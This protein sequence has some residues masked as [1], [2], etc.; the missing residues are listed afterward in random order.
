MFIA[1]RGN[2]ND[3]LCRNDMFQTMDWSTPPYIPLL[4]SL[5]NILPTRSYKH[6]VPT[7][8]R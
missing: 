5:R 4:W 3:Q 6:F 1:L 8:L 2:A 7:G